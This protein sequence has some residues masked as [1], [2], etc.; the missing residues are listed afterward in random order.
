MNIDVK[1]KK[2]ENGEIT[3]PDGHVAVS[4]HSKSWKMVDQIDQLEEEYTSKD[5]A[6]DA[7]VKQRMISEMGNFN[8]FVKVAAEKGE[9]VFIHLFV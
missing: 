8:V 6:L 1:W 9:L 3:S 7:G 5:E 4:K 2:N